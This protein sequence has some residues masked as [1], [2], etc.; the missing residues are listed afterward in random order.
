VFRFIG[1]IGKTERR[2]VAALLATAILP[3]LAAMWWANGVINN[4][5]RTAFH[6]EYF[7][8][9]ERSLDLYKELVASMKRAMRNEG[10]L[11]AERHTLRLAAQGADQGALKRE[12]ERALTEHPTLLSIAVQDAEGEEI[13]TRKRAT[14]IDE[15]RERAFTVNMP[16]GEGAEAPTLVTVF[17][18]D[19]TRLDELEG[20]HQFVQAYKSFAN[21]HLGEWLSRP[22]LLGF[23]ALLG[24]TLLL[25]IITGIMVVRP[26]MRRLDRLAAATRPVAEGDLSV[27]VADTGRDEIGDLARSFNQML[28]Q[29]ERS[30]ARIEFL[31]RIGEWQQMARRLAHEI[32]NPL[33][34]IQLA[35]EECHRRYSGE[36]AS[37]KKLLSTTLDIVVEEV[38]SLRRLV[39]EFAEFAR[40][41]RADLRRGDVREFL[42]EQKP[43][44]LRDEV[45]GAEGSAVEV[46]VE[47]PEEEI[48]VA[49]DRTMLYRVL[50]NLVQ[51][52]AQASSGDGGAGV[53]K[54]HAERDLDSCVLEVEDDGPGVPE[55]M[56]QSV[57]D[58]Y[59]TTKKDGTGLGL[60]IVKKVVIDHGGH[61]DVDDSPLGG[62]RFRIR[63]PLWGTSASEVALTRSERHP[64][65]G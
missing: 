46:E 33:T 44:L 38:Q 47:V 57:F 65:S 45:A 26:L 59:V 13:S 35:V 39:G 21:K 48:P 42:V 25:A 56:R 22:H 7:D 8:H 54:V 41:P 11:I 10:A 1:K 14:P 19:R 55:E 16:L 53:V 43:R 4:V 3:L 31:K 37:Y 32:K 18:A 24:C 23:G 40:L 27:R 29:L 17:A 36:D 28:E 64:L 6:Q 34:P 63:L 9:L 62:A 30:R 5:T 2:V 49:M 60:T 50:S 51:N 15:A 61:I 12:L 58:P 52:A 20:A